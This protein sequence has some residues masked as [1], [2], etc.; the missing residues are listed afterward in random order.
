MF[1]LRDEH[2]CRLRTR[3]TETV[4]PPLA[5]RLPLCSFL[6]SLFNVWPPDLAGQTAPAQQPAAEPARRYNILVSN[7]V[8]F[9]VPRALLNAQAYDVSVLQVSG[10]EV[11]LCSSFAA[12]GGCFF[13]AAGSVPM[14]PCTPDSA[15]PSPRRAE[16][17]AIRNGFST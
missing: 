7:G 4:Q 8:V 6:S 10:H 16:L 5:S 11:K 1:Q 3:S 2:Q 15:E 14:H 13:P 17:D 9:V 12:R